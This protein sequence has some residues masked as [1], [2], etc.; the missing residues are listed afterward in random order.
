[1]SVAAN[2]PTWAQ[3]LRDTAA[4]LN[5][6]I[7][8]ETDLVT[9]AQFHHN[10]T[11]IRTRLNQ[12]IVEAFGRK[13]PITA[14]HRLIASLPIETIWTTNYDKLIENSF[15][16]VG[17]RVDVRITKGNFTAPMRGK[18]VTLYKMHGDVGTPEVATL[19]KDDYEVYGIKNEIFFNALK[20][21]LVSKT[22]LFLGF[23]FTDPNIDYILSRIRLSMGE[24]AQQHY[25]V[26]R[27]PQK[28]L[29]EQ[30]MKANAC[31]D[32]DMVRLQL[33]IGDLKRY[34]IKALMID[35][36]A[37]ITEIL[38]TLNRRVHSKNIM[39]SGSV[40][41]YPVMDQKRLEDLSVL[42]GRETIKRGYNLVS[43]VGLGIGGS[44]LIGALTQF[45]QPD[46]DNG[47][48]TDRITMRPFPQIDRNDPKRKEVNT[49]YRR[50]MIT[51]VG[52]TVFVSGN[53]VDA[54]GVQIPAD[55]VREEFAIS[56]EL[57]KLP[58]PIGATGDMAREIWGE[59]TADLAQ[60][61]PTVNAKKLTELGEL[62]DIL[63][64]TSHDN[65]A[66]V[67]AVFKIIA[68]TQT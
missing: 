44:V 50:D 48:L 27:W 21:D 43:G 39:I 11:G 40:S 3:L 59:V 19:T 16:E 54:T 30:D 61:F 52:Y 2:L 55:G 6:D 14:N 31:Y 24:N 67:D 62:F 10:E 37:E 20:G 51:T 57:G 12:L 26:M 25:F 41:V 45:Y 53:K 1:M 46:Q 36:F 17:K 68:L 18:D 22:F 35:D 47:R 15:N 38:E 4:E 42:L 56:A 34:G 9:L 49:Q 58:I 64:D 65:Q 23:S 32:Y 28:P 66:W 7:D 33:R 13:V 63:G 60:F 8:Q 29:D 5:L